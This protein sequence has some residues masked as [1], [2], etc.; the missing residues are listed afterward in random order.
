[1]HFYD[2]SIDERDP[3]LEHVDDILGLLE[4]NQHAW[5]ENKIFQS[6]QIGDRIRRRIESLLGL[7]RERSD[8]QAQVVRAAAASFLARRVW[9]AKLRQRFH[10]EL[11][12]ATL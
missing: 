9:T 10:G 2:R 6:R 3:L 12:C 7:C 5:N 8:E 1:M 4:S 11:Q